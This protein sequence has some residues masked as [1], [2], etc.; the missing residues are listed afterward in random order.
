M[1]LLPDAEPVGD[2][3]LGGAPDCSA[4][5]T[6]SPDAMILSIVETWQ[7]QIEK[8]IP[9]GRGVVCRDSAPFADDAGCDGT[10][11]L[12]ARVEW[13]EVASGDGPD[14]RRQFALA[15]APR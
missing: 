9:T 3:P 1:R 15:I 10:G 14:I 5:A 8:D 7:R 6:C 2:A 13:R 11:V 4:A 12:A